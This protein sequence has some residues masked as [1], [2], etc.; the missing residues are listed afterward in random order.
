MR[1]KAIEE[2]N[3]SWKLRSHWN[4]S[5]LLKL[6]ENAQHHQSGKPRTDTKAQKHLGNENTDLDLLIITSGS[7]R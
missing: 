5:D 2:E 6:S 3:N 7:G 4:C 1:T